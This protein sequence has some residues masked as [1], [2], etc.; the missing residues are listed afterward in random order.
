VIAID[1]D[2][3]K[4][5]QKIFFETSTTAI[6]M[7]LVLNDKTIGSPPMVSWLPIQGIYKLSLMKADG[8]VVDQINFEVR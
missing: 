7:R 2:I 5:V 6:D 1:P 3:P 8:Q 4:D